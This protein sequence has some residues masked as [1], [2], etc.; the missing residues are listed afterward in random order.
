MVPFNFNYIF[1]KE[2]IKKKEKDCASPK[3]GSC[4][5]CIMVLGSYM[6]ETENEIE[7]MVLFYF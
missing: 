3:L 6:E 2:K 5:K 1:N 4:G 7:V